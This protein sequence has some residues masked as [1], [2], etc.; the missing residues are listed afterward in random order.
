VADIHMQIA[1][2]VAAL[3][4]TVG[5]YTTTLFTTRIYITGLAI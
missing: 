5:T 3:V 4:L 1:S 2:I